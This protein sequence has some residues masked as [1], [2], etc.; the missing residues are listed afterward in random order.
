MM[1]FHFACFADHLGY[2]RK[3]KECSTKSSWCKGK[4]GDSLQK[5]YI[6]PNLGGFKLDLTSYL[7]SL[8]TRV[9]SEVA[10]TVPSELAFHILVQVLSKHL[11]RDPIETGSDPELLRH[12]IRLGFERKYRLGSDT[13]P[14]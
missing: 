10:P 11:L 3:T 2:Q 8:V 1:Y 6:P 9:L 12:W 5:L 14:F 7:E 13:M 4:S